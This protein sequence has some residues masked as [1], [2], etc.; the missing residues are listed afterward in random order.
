MK[1]GEGGGGGGGDEGWG[2]EGKSEKKR[3]RYECYKLLA[4]CLPTYVYGST[5]YPGADISMK[6]Y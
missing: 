1:R 4:D 5:K 2:G 6:H 3:E